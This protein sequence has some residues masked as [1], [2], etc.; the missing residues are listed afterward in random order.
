MEALGFFFDAWHWLQAAALMLAIALAGLLLL[1]ALIVGYLPFAEDIP[2]IKGYVIA[3]RF[4]VVLAFGALTAL[5]TLQLLG[6]SCEA[7]RAADREAAEAARVTRDDT[8]RQD[9]EKTYRPELGRLTAL[10]AELQKK[11]DDYAKHPP[12]ARAAR[13]KAAASGSVCRLGDAALRLRP[14]SP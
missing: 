11:V 3:A 1:V 8:I 2:A 7:Q 12:A 4:V 6:S 14:R 13:P 5:I 10:S 9:L